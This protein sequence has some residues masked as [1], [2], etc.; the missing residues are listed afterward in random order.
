VLARLALLALAVLGAGVAVHGLRAKAGCDHAGDR[1]AAAI[2]ARGDLGGAASAVAA[3]CDATRDLVDG[4]VRLTA[5]GDRRDALLLS[6]RATQ[7]APRDYLGWLAVG[8]ILPAGDPGARRALARARELA[9][10]VR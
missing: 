8:R 6:R 2:S 1:L 9:P 3:D 10:P 7:R 5:A 4:A